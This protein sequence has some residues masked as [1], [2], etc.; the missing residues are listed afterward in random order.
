MKCT[1]VYRQNAE[2]NTIMFVVCHSS[3]ID[4]SSL[5]VNSKQLVTR[6]VYTSW[7]DLGSGCR[8][9]LYNMDD[10]SEPTSILWSRK[11]VHEQG[12]P[13]HARGW[14]NSWRA[15][16]SSAWRLPQPSQRL[17]RL[18]LAYN[19]TRGLWKTGMLLGSN[20]AFEFLLLQNSAVDRK[21]HVQLGCS[22]GNPSRYLGQ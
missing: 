20:V 6:S 8:G 2:E 16:A 11:S 3:P 5:A 4:F 13:A 21:N 1:K 15:R 9:C 10:S 14:P 7:A 18:R 22:E 19:D 12:I 17:V